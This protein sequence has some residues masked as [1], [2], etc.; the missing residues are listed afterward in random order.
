M[1]KILFNRMAFYGYHGAFK[2][3][4]TLG[5]RFY[6]DLELFLD[7]AKPG[8]SDKLEDTV[9][10]ADIY[11]AVRAIVEGERYELVEAVAERIADKILAEFPLIQQTLVRV[12]KPD[13]PIPGH[14]ESVA[15]EIK[16]SRSGRES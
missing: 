13:P 9:N 8:H 6:V 4:N 7:L 14:Y 12:I 11:T 1:D 16:R 10:Y 3:E 5:Q 15:V 2:E